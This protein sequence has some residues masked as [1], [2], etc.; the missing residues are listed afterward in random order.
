MQINETT[1]FCQSCMER[2]GKSDILA[3]R[4]WRPGY[5]ICEDCFRPLV[6]NVFSD[7]GLM[8]GQ[9]VAK[10]E[11][12]SQVDPNKP[13]LNQFY[14][15]LNVPELL[16]YQRQD[17]LLNHRNDIYLHFAPLVENLD[18]KECVAKIEDLRVIFSFCKEVASL[19]AEKIQLLKSKEREKYHISGE[20]K[21]IKEVTKVKKSTATLSQKEKLAKMAGVSVEELE[22]MMTVSKGVQKIENE[23][24][25]NQIIGKPT[26]GK[27]RKAFIK[28]GKPA[29]CQR[30]F[31]H[32]GE[33]SLELQTV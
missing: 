23:N 30:M 12:I 29:I 31:G 5:F 26:D 21:S 2:Y 18:L 14:E 24:K 27:C 17:E 13:L 4:E 9:A 19:H 32:N 3:T 25:F 1:K 15:L 8:N 22:K 33:H 16:R 28:D 11:V 10:S 20:E 7:S 6:D